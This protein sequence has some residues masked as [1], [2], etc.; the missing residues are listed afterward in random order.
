MVAWWLRAITVWNLAVLVV[1]LAWAWPQSVPVALAG[2]V[3]WALGARLWIGSQFVC[4]ALVKRQRGEPLQPLGGLLRAWNAECRLSMRAF[5]WDMPWAE[6][7][8]ADYVPDRQVGSA[9]VVLVHG[10]LCNRAMWADALHQLRAAGVPC[11]A[12][13]MPLWLHRIGTGRAVLDAAARRMQVATGCRPVVVAHSMGGLIVRDWLRSLSDPQALHRPGT[14]ITVGS[15]HH[16]TWS[17]QLALGANVAQMRPGNPW[18]QQLAQEEARPGSAA[19]QVQW[20]CA[21]SDTDNLVYPGT[22]ALLDG[23]TPLWLHGWAHVEM[24][25]AP[26]LWVLVRAQVEQ[27]P[28]AA[29]GSSSAPSTPGAPEGVTG[30]PDLEAGSEH[31]EPKSIM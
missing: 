9:G 8:Q 10:W 28:Q 12:V 21:L 11:V 14:V 1:W 15:P 25:Q 24:L 16:G 26:A 30:A 22:T 3:L 17:A 2:A 4:M 19:R 29:A 23:A 13:S 20:H 6:H 27:A 18:L 5:G 31:A 7:A